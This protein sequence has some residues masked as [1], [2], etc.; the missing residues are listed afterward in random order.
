[1]HDDGD[2]DGDYVYDFHITNEKECQVGVDRSSQ[3][4]SWSSCNGRGREVEGA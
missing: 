4:P 3:V 2:G 1:M